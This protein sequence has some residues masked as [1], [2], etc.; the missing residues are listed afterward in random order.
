MELLPSSGSL[1]P[2]T[3]VWSPSGAFLAAASDDYQTTY[4]WNVDDWSMHTISGTSPRWSPIDDSLLVQRADR[5]SVVAIWNIKTLKEVARFTRHNG[6]VYD[7]EW[8]ERGKL[9]ASTAADSTLRI[10]DSTTGDQLFVIATGEEGRNWVAW[11]PI[12]FQV[13]SLLQSQG[14]KVYD[15]TIGQEPSR[16]CQGVGR[17]MS[18][19]D[20]R[21]YMGDQKYR[22][23]CP[24]KPIP[25][26][27]IPLKPTPGSVG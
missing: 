27:D 26:L 16:F 24:G 17:N 3:V 21:T 9:I 25:G 15:L 22:K 4:V 23:T 8:D 6:A 11:D 10:W 13:A 19:D 7:A 5:V 12:G 20:W 14:F 18:E 2:S 1:L